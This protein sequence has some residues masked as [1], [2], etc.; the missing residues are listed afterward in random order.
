MFKSIFFFLL[1]LRD[2][3]LREC[4]GYFMRTGINPSACTR[5]RSPLTVT[6]MINIT[7]FLTGK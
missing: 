5:H 3:F 1:L 4:N 6:E 2:E 7:V